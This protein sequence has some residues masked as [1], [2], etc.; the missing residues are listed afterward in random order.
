MQTALP[1]LEAAGGPVVHGRPSKRKPKSL[2]VEGLKH[3]A[4]S[5]TGLLCGYLVVGFF[6]PAWDHYGLFHR[7]SVASNPVQ[8]GPKPD[9]KEPPDS[10][11]PI[12]NPPSLPVQRIQ[13]APSNPPAGDPPA[14]DPAVKPPTVKPME[15]P[16]PPVPTAEELALQAEKEKRERLSQL[17]ADRAAAVAA[18]EVV[19]ALKLTA[20][21]AQLSELDPRAEKA[22]VIEELRKVDH[23]PAETFILTGA[24]LEQ[25]RHA[26]Q[27]NHKELAAEQ[28]TAALQLARKTADQDLVRQAT[29]LILEIQQ[30]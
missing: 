25:A 18:G 14:V 2:L 9:P 1:K 10:Q 13:P 21:F 7:K 19:Q 4:A 6:S 16:L 11:P 26:L 15:K 8:P 20:E 29:K 22:R 24:I 27:N 17:Q 23:S 28:A 5:A 12:N 3:V 30:P